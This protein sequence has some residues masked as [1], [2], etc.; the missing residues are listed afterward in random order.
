VPAVHEQELKKIWQSG[1]AGREALREEISWEYIAEQNFL[2]HPDKNAQFTFRHRNR[3]VTPPGAGI[4]FW[5]DANK[6]LEFDENKNA[7]FLKYV[8][9]NCALYST[10]AFR[11]GAYVFLARLPPA[12][13]PAFDSLH[14]GAETT[15]AAWLG[16][17]DFYFDIYAGAIRTQL[18]SYPLTR[19]PALTLDA[20]ALVSDPSADYHLYT[21]KVN[22]ASVEYYQD[23][24]LIAIIQFS[25]QANRYTVRTGAPYIL[26]QQK[27]SIPA[28]QPCL[29]EWHSSA[30]E[31]IGARS[32]IIIRN[33]AVTDGDPAPPR[34]LHPYTGNATWEGTSIDS[35]TLT[36]DRIPIAGYDRK[37]IFFMADVAGTLF[38]DVDYG[39]NSDDEYD[40]VSVSANELVSYVMTANPL[41]LRLRFEPTSYPATVTRARVAMS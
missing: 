20:S 27:G 14:L 26:A 5:G 18:L 36:S 1:G 24:N 10:R 33:I 32:N 6:A 34:T 7:F 4:V 25:E 38:I 28:V 31:Y 21:M 15:G 13:D 29:I 3:F 23:G 22:R 41:W 37:T 16:I 39:D 11:Y 17:T 12:T 2:F 30:E 8:N 9:T 19:Y 35:G 40:S